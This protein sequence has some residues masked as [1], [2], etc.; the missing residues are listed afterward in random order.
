MML[1]LAAWRL[2]L[3]LFKHAL[4]V[5][6][7]AFFGYHYASTPPSCAG[8]SPRGAECGVSRITS[9]RLMGQEINAPSN[10]L[11]A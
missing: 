3:R 8:W 4:R 2:I 5:E 11:V 6:R 7:F 10:V 1:P 9:P